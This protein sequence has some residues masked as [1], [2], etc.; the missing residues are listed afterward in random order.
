M[1][2]IEAIKKRRAYRSLD[3]VNIS[4]EIIKN[5]AD[6]AQIAPSCMNNQP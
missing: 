3:P 4:N 6:I 5:F 1:D 2:V